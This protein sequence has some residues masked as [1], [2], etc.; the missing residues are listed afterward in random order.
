LG[1]GLT[2]S[3]RKSHVSKPEEQETMARYRAVAPQ[4]KKKKKKKKKTANVRA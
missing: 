2:T 3:L 4:K 1:E